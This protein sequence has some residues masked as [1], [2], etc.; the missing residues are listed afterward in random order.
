M[1]ILFFPASAECKIITYVV[2][3]CGVCA[4]TKH[5]HITQLRLIKEGK[6]DQINYTFPI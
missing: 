1:V 6:Y 3:M 2:V 4:K 5:V